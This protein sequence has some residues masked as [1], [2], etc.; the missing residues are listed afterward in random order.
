M[1]RLLNLIFILLLYTCNTESQNTNKKVGGPCQGCEAIYEYGDKVLKPVD[2]L[3]D[4][5]VLPNP[6]KISG[7][8]YEIDSNTVAKVYHDGITPIGLKKFQFLSGLDPNY[9]VPPIELNII[10]SIP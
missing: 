5:K 9:F 10:V 7:T 4:F 2:T 8:V 3:P 6:I 1:N